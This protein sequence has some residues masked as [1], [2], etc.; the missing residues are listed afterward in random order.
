MYK[1]DKQSIKV[2]LKY[3]KKDSYLYRLPQLLGEDVNQPVQVLAGVAFGH[4]AHTSL[5][6][7]R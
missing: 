3:I 7:Q 6:G 1:N 4:S 5:A 2:R